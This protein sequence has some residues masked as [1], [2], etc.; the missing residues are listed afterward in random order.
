MF[1]IAGPAGRPAPRR[2]P[3]VRFQ[4]GLTCRTSDGRLV[5]LSKAK[6]A[7]PIEG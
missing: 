7:E 3:T 6:V 5:K 4:G 2:P 1:A